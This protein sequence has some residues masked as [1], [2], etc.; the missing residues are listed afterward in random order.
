LLQDE[1]LGYK[2]DDSGQLEY[3]WVKSLT[4][5]GVAELVKFG[6]QEGLATAQVL[7][8]SGI[9]EAMLSDPYA[10]IGASQEFCV[11]RNLHALLGDEALGLRVGKQFHLS[12]LGVLG[13]A[14]PNAANVLEAIRFFN[15]FVRLSYTYFTVHFEATPEGGRLVLID[16]SNLSDLRR[17]FIDRDVMFTLNAFRDLLPA[18]DYRPHLQ[19]TLGYETPLAIE[20]YQT[21]MGC[22]VRF[23]EGSTEIRIDR[24]LLAVPLPQSN[25]LTLKLL[26]QSCIALDQKL[27]GTRQLSE[28]VLQALLENLPSPPH[29]DDLAD[30]FCISAR[31]LRRRLKLEGSSYQHLLNQVRSSEAKRLLRETQW[32]IDRIAGYLGY[33]ESAAFI[34][35]FQGWNQISPGSYRQ[36]I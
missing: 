36:S 8:H 16:G 6:R 14:V 28:R 17:F 26:E 12:V 11:I 19:V 9:H 23:R 2:V 30:R 18:V 3:I 4:I 33:S 10:M 7:A 21:A 1:T 20:R 35:A 13:A 24:H 32:S 31:T 29:L 27:D 34:H 25:A 15:H 22:P 5:N